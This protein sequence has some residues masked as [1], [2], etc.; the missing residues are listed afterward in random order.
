MKKIFV[1]LFL[2]VSLTSFAQ[3]NVGIGTNTP[4]A[5]A[6]LEVA[7]ANKGFLLPR[8]ALTGTADVTTIAAPAT[9]LLIYNTATAG[10]A[11]S[12]V[13]PGFYYY[14][15][16]AW[17][18]INNS[19]TG[20]LPTVTTTSISSIT[21]DKAT[22][23]GE[24]TGDG[25][26]LITARGICM[27]TTINPTLSNT[28]LTASSTGPGGFTSNINGLTPSTNYF[29][30]AFATNVN[31][32]AFGANYRFITLVGSVP[33]V[34]TSTIS[35]ITGGSA[36]VRAQIISNGNGTI[37]ASGVCYAATA[38]PTTANSIVPSSTTLGVYFSNI[39]G[40]TPLTQYHVRA[41]AT[42]A[43]GTAYGADSVFT[44]VAAVLP[45]LT[46]NTVTNIGFSSA[47]VGGNITDDGGGMIT[48]RGVCYSNLPDPTTANSVIVNNGTGA[49]FFSDTI[50]SGLPPSSVIHARAYAINAAGTAYGQDVSFTTLAPGGFSARFSF[51]SVKTNSGVNDPTP[52]PV[53]PGVILTPFT[54]VGVGP[55]SSVAG[56]FSLPGWSLGATNGSDVFTSSIDTLT[57]YYEFTIRPESTQTLTLTT[58]SFRVQRSSTGPRQYFVRAGGLPQN[59]N[60]SINP[61]NANLSIVSINK[62]Q[63]PDGLTTAQDG[64]TINFSPPFTNMNFPATIRIYGI[65]AEGSG[66]TFSIDEV[67]IN[68]SVN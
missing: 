15:S 40:L 1:T 30:R 43:T 57:K 42:N 16:N 33:V 67:I 66:G 8:I 60:A 4:D 61:A 38:N 62:F 52:L 7:S 47:I 29:V 65:N 37:T 49:G 27:A 10:T 25:G 20:G 32:T 35:N 18:R 68:G 14:N 28:V 13:F 5:S 21:A 34:E 2:T 46:T 50:Q 22:S 19:T 41:Y 59:E 51:D 54:A 56:R 55:N 17:E 26:A 3:Q 11:P 24:V 48:Q 31:G 45:T 9:G 44:T 6:Q 64:S 58:M 12:N 53:I 63:I 23:G 36:R 39:T